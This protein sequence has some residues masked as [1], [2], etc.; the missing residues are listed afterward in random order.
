MANIIYT[1]FMY[2]VAKNNIDM[3]TALFVAM[4]EEDASTYVPSKTHTTVAGMSGFVEVS[5]S[6][7]ARE[8][9]GSNAITI[10]NTSHRVEFDTADIDFGAIGSGQEIK[11]IVIYVD[12]GNPGTETDDIPVANIDTVSGS[13][14]LPLL[15]NGGTVKFVIDST[16]LFHIQQ[17]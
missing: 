17:G 10:N 3:D 14:S 15:T 7:Y 2:Q 1:N 12:G 16:G 9:L 5:A 8:N 13:P 6:G 11:A 4:L